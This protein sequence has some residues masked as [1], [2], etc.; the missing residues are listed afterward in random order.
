VI[1][2]LYDLKGQPLPNAV[3]VGSVA[4]CIPYKGRIFVLQGH[5]YHE[6]TVTRVLR[7]IDAP[8]IPAT[9]TSPS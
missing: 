4:G 8:L 2:E 1:V 6:V 3:E 7:E 9:T 5:E